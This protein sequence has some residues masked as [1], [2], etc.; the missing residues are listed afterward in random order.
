M[1][2]LVAART[3][4]SSLGQFR[5]MVITA[6]KD[7]SVRRL[8]LEMATQAERLVA[9]DQQHRI[10]AA[11]RVV[12]SGAAFTNGLMFKHEGTRLRDV[13]PGADFVGRHKP[14]PAALAAIGDRRA[15]MWI[16]T[17][18]ASDFALDNGVV[19]RQIKLC[20][21]VEMALETCLRRLARID[22]R[23]RRTAR[24]HMQA[25]GPVARFTPDILG[26]VTGR[27]QAKMG[28]GGEAFGDVLMASLASF[29]T[30]KGGSWDL[31]RGHRLRLAHVGARNHAEGDQ[32]AKQQKQH[33]G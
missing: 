26:V 28:R 3:P 17:V 21:L 20:P 25:A 27:L 15:F 11:V 13:A 9:C 14:S 19:R 4:T 5:G 32:Y 23:L 29:G 22:N 24:G 8:L 18:T 31:R 33:P 10:D 12:A 1:N 6:D 30:D 16:V 2:G 7:F